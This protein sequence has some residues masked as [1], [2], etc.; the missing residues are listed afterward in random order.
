MP[1]ASPAAPASLRASAGEIALAL[2]RVTFQRTASLTPGPPPAPHSV[3]LSEKREES[4]EAV[5]EFALG[6]RDP[7]ALDRVVA[8]GL[9]GAAG[10]RARDSQGRLAAPVTAQ[11]VTTDDGPRLRV[12]IR[13]LSPGASGLSSLEG[14]LLAFP[15]ARRIRFH[16]PWL[17]DEAPLQVE[18]QGGV[19]TLKRFQLVEGDSTL[20]V[21]VR[22]P[23]GFRV[24]PLAQPGA[25][26]ARALDIYG[27]LVN[28]G[29]I[30]Q[31]EQT[32]FNAE[33]EFRFFAP[34]LRRTPSRLM[35]DVLCV[36]G[37][38]RSLPFHFGNLP[39]PPPGR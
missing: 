2:R 14:A 13:G 23:E 1:T 3:P 4:A 37:E 9:A 36:A 28:G 18:V 12:T 27:N 6:A 16:V 8:G 31:A 5:L 38:P 25:V 33:P 30:T 17:K 20:W 32:G 24:L 29:G 34:A 35:L 10:F 21:S 7:E 19:A 26:T 15:Q 39:F 11:V 22:P